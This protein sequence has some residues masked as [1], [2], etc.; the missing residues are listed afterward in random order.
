MPDLDIKIIRYGDAPP[1]ADIPLGA[2]EHVP[3]IASIAILEGGMS[4][5]LPSVAVRVNIPGKAPRVVLA[6]TSLRLFIGALAAARGAFP[7]AFEGGPFQEGAPSVTKLVKV[8]EARDLLASYGNHLEAGQSI[9]VERAL[10]L[11]NEALG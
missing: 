8:I 2:L 7:E 9:V 3:D 5:G 11:L 10:Q 4:S 6:E 1:W